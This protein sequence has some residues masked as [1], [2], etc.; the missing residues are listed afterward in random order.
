MGK[1]AVIGGAGF[2]GCNL[3]RRLM[4]E[5]KEV[6]VVDNLCRK[7]AEANLQWLRSKGRITFVAADIRDAHA[8]EA[9]FTDY[10]EIDAAVHLAGQVA[11]TT[12]VANPREDFEVNAAGTFNVLEGIRLSKQRPLLIYASTNKVYGGMEEIA[13]EERETRYGYRDYP[14]G[15][16]E[17]AP[18]D[19]HSPY[20][21]SKGAADQYVRDYAR[22]YELP[23]TV[24][25]QSC[26]YGY[27]QF[28]VEDQG[29]VAWFVIAAVLGRPITIY[30]NGKQVRDVLFVDDLV[31]AYLAAIARPETVAGKIFNVGGG[32]ENTMSVW[33]EFGPMLEELIGRPVS[34]AHGDW[35]PGDQPVYISDIRKIARELGWQPKIA[36]RDGV[37]KLYEWVA[38][39]RDLFKILG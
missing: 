29:W 9:L 30:G 15:I 24:Y 37:Q 20:G 10:G 13:V 33:A 2:I 8:M 31:E 16:P 7:G 35:R 3:V 12:S 39:H 38:A 1:C 18:L 28:G 17:T 19:F 5:D 11:V 21:C 26:I 14:H 22:I 25:R 23:T 4:A 34:V 27:R 36:V 6:L 32:P